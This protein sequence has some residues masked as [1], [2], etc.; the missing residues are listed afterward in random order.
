M[1][2]LSRLTALLL[3]M[4]IASFL[5]LHTAIAEVDQLNVVAPEESFPRV[6][7]AYPDM[8]ARFARPG[9]PR[10]PAQVRAVQIGSTKVQL[11]RAVGQPVSAYKDGSWNFDIALPLPQR[12]RLICQYRVFFDDQ[13]RV[14]GTIWRRP[15]CAELV[16]GQRK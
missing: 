1:N 11:V 2:K 9:E 3:G 15:Q 12:N 5:P 7:R 8:D 6:W 13:D 4:A 14:A 10:T 16:V